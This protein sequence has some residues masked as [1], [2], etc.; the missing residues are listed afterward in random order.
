MHAHCIRPYSHSLSDDER[1]Y[2]TKHER[3]E[4][5]LRDP[6]VTFPKFLIEE[7]VIERHELEQ[8]VREIDH[9]I[10]RRHARAR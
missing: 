9:E 7:G 5:A 8:M 3:E 2:K 4:E 10:L 6:L 1:L